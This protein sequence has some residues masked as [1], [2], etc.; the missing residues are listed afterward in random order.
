MNKLLSFLLIAFST[1]LFSQNYTLTS[2]VVNSL[3]D[4]WCGDIEETNW[5]FIGC[6]A[7]PDPYATL[8]DANGNT[9][10]QSASNVDNFSLELALN[11][12]LT[13]FP[14]TLTIWDEDGVIGG[15]GSSDDNLGNFTLD[16]S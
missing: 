3:N 10:Y 14:Y 2:V 13:D 1:S 5:P 12:P 16:G 7:S 9:V 15:V 6:T 11:I 8:T 4:S